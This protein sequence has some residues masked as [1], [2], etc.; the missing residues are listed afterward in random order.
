MLPPFAHAAMRCD[1]ASSAGI[2]A[3]PLGRNTPGSVRNIIRCKWQAPGKGLAGSLMAETWPKT[4]HSWTEALWAVDLLVSPQ[5]FQLEASWKTHLGM[6]RVQREP[7]RY[8]RPPSGLP[9]T[10]STLASE[11]EHRTAAV[12]GVAYRTASGT[13]AT[14]VQLPPLLPL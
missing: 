6:G 13:V 2:A 9:R 12:P 14:S 8:V 5:V 10:R 4:G 1:P 11:G 3:Q 7:T